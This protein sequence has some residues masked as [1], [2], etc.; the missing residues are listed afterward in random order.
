MRLLCHLATCTQLPLGLRTTDAR[1]VPAALP[2]WR[3]PTTKHKRFF[4]PRSCLG[5]GT[6]DV[7]TTNLEDHAERVCTHQPLSKGTGNS[8]LSLESSDS[9][10]SLQVFGLTHLSADSEPAEWIWRNRPSAVI[11][12]T[13]VNPIHG[14][15]TGSIVTTASVEQAAT[16]F[17]LRMFIQIAGQLSDA[18]MQASSESKIWSMVK[19]QFPGE[20]LA[21]IAALAVGAELVFGDRPKAITYQRLQNIPSLADLDASYERLS[22]DNYQDLLDKHAHSASESRSPVDSDTESGSRPDSV[23]TILTDERDL[24]LANSMIRAAKKIGEEGKV[25]G[26]IGAAHM[27]GVLRYLRSPNIDGNAALKV[28]QS[29]VPPEESPQQQG[30]RRALLTSCLT[31]CC[32]AEVVTDCT[33][34]LGE[35]PSVAQEAEQQTTEIYGST[36]MLLAVLS[37]EELRKVCSGWQCDMHEILR[38]VRA[39]RPSNGGAGVDED[40][41]WDHVRDL[42]LVIG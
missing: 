38:P 15:D 5:T 41:L 13:A 7:K 30:V 6:T 28:L 11:F 25:A 34:T 3:K 27:A 24:V 10:S 40:V 1:T 18:T 21:Y 8:S 2:S 39:V 35:L 42:S 33:A 36:R 12:E 17:R 23:R 14:A 20:Q 29:G 9:H 31:L 22:A 19:Q 37:K 32:P 4:G 16:D 26:V